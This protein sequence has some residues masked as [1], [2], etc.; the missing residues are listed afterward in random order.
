MLKQRHQL[1][2]TLL[3]MVD[4]MVATAACCLAWAIRVRLL[5]GVWPDL[6]TTSRWL[7]SVRESL[8]LLEL[9]LLVMCMW[10]FGLYRP[11]RDRT[12]V[13]ET[14]QLLKAAFISL[15]MLIV[16]LWALGPRFVGDWLVMDAGT[17]GS[18]PVDAPRLQLAALALL[19]CAHRGTIDQSTATA[20]VDA[21]LTDARAKVES[22]AL[23]GLTLTGYNTW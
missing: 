20:F 4:A 21:R 16:V 3:S 23:A 6:S 8:L 17:V 19:E 9:P 10:A 22:L 15:V 14:L 2:V 7:V 5:E 1:F 13:A 11:R 12:L 18:F